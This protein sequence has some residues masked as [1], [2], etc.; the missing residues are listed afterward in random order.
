MESSK[1]IW[2]RDCYN[3]PVDIEMGCEHQDIGNNTS[4]DFCICGEN[5]CNKDM[6]PIPTVTTSTYK[7][8]P[9]TS[10]HSGNNTLSTNVK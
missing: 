9:T 5:L 6:G 7:T 2:V 4:I 3:R 1:E 10:S 8:T